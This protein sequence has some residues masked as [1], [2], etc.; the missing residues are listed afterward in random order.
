VKMNSAIKSHAVTTGPKA[1]RQIIFIIRKLIIVA[2][3]HFGLFPKKF[4]NIS[5]LL[6]FAIDL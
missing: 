3:N 1:Y 6:Y 4:F 2:L 5:S